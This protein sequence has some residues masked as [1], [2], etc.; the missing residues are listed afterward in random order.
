M[1]SIFKFSNFQIFEFRQILFAFLILATNSATAQLEKDPTLNHVAV[2]VHDLQKSADFYK[3]IIGLKS[4]PEPFHDGHHDWFSIG[5]HSQ[6]HLIEGASSV[7]NHDKNSHLCFTV[8]S[9]GDFINKLNKNKIS[10]ENWPGQANEITIRTDGIKQIYFKDP[11][12][13]WIEINN[14]TY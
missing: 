9:I 8:S 6:L 5:P 10:F 12:G 4:I 1:S 14:D 3:N 7:V 2:Y 11:D 13:Y